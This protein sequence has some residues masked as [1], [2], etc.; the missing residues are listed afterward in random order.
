[1][2]VDL[3]EPVDPTIAQVDPGAT[4]NETFRR[5]GRAGSYLD[6]WMCVGEWVRVCVSD[7]WNPFVLFQYQVFN[8]KFNPRTI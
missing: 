7:K 3:P 4:L 5:I 6:T 8:I 1:M 2:I